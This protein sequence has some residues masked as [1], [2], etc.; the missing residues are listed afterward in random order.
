MDPILTETA[1][2]GGTGMVCGAVL[3]VAAKYLAVHEDPR[4]EAVT[5]MLPGVNC[6][7]CGFAGCGEYAR[8]VVL[9][10]APANKCGPGGADTVHKVAQFMGVEV[11][12]AV[13]QVALVLCNGDD[14]VARRI[15]Q[16]N[17][18]CD[19]NM[20]ESVSGGGKACRYGC[21]GYGSCSRVCPT[22][23]IQTSGQLAAVN[24]TLCIGCGQCV[25]T[26]PRKLIKM[27]PET[28]FIHVLCKSP[29]RGAD[30]KRV[31]DVGCIGCTLCA[32][33]VANV[34]IKMDGALAVVDY[35]VPVEN[36]DAI[37][38][39]PQHTIVAR[40]GQRQEVS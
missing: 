26:C 30:V 24:P 5:G 13:R 37:A 9:D 11:T 29:D 31:C 19:C 36:R 22:G 8:A 10:G 4:V 39:C 12:S 15:S 17:G 6:G 40:P 32:K 34:G 3:A 14:K 7:G 2:I 23:A 38:K 27:V 1:I 25:A 28:A 16:Y 35:S 20:A 33:A 18:I 21:L